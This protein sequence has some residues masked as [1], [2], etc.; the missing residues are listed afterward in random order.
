MG[1]LR[2]RPNPRLKSFSS[3]TIKKKKNINR[4]IYPNQPKEITPALIIEVVSEHFGVS[5]EDIT[6][7]KRNS[8][9]VLPRQIVMYLCREMTETSLVNIGKILGKKDH[10]TVLHGIKRVTEELTTNDELR[11]KVE[12]IKKK[13]IPN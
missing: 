12:I 11:N 4:G 13:M 7:K 8:E 9:Y 10:T 5:A 6:S 1:G 3:S 2:S